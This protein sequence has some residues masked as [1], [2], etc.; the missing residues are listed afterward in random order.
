MGEQLASGR[1]RLGTPADPLDQAQAD[2]VLELADLQADRRLGEIE[3]RRRGRKA[4]ELGD[5]S[6]GVK[7]VEIDASHSNYFL[8]HS[9]E[10]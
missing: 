8:Y 5:L 9:L 4:T 7:V 10:Q 6:Q 3:A 1:C 2:A